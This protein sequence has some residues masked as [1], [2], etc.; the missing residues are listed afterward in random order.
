MHLIAG[1]GLASLRRNRKHGGSRYRG[2]IADT[3]ARA[4]EKIRRRERCSYEK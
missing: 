4:T 1:V 2:V 3:E